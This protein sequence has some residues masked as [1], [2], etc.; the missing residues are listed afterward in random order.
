MRRAT[1]KVPVSWSHVRVV[2]I[3]DGPDHVGDLDGA[4]PTLLEAAVMTAKSPLAS[5]RTSISAP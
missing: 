5:W 1:S 3:R 2:A 4:T